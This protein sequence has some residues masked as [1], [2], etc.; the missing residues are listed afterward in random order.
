[1]VTSPPVDCGIHREPTSTRPPWGRDQREEYRSRPSDAILHL[2]ILPILIR[3][4]VR[5]FNR[6]FLR[7]LRILGYELTSS[8]AACLLACLS[9]ARVVRHSVLESYHGLSLLM[10]VAR[11]GLT[12]LLLWGSACSVLARHGGVELLGVGK[13]GQEARKKGEQSYWCTSPN[14]RSPVG[15]ISD[16]TAD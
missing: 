14:C 2:R 6:M 9:D 13:L 10:R 7:M 5:V 4:G 8:G 11:T 3:D 12:P 15:I 16:Q 1:M